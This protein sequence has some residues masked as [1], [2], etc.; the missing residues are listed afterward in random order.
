MGPPGCGKTSMVFQAAAECQVVVKTVDGPELANPL[1]G[2]SERLLGRIFDECKLLAEEC[3][4]F[5]ILLN[6]LS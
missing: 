5:I 2:E 6:F 3:P 1:P 4:G